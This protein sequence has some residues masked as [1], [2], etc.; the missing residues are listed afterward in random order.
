MP[1]YEITFIHN[2]RQHAAMLSGW[3][4]RGAKEQL[5]SLKATG[6]VSDEIVMIIQAPE[7]TIVEVRDE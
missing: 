7:L 2:G 4:Y 3:N 1:D 6:I 5:D